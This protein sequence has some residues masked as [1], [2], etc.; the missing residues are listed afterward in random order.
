MSHYVKFRAEVIND[1][2]D[3][4]KVMPKGP[5]LNV[6][7]QHLKF[8]NGTDMPDV[9]ITMELRDGFGLTDLMDCM[10][11]VEDNHVM[12]DTLATAENYTGE[13]DYLGT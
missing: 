6:V 9:E 3:L 13:R 4:L 7:H 2:A 12:V 11:K 1:V 5:L 8:P 10:L